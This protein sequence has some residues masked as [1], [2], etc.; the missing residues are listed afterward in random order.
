M[1]SYRKIG[2]AF[3]TSKCCTYVELE[4][5][6]IE[7]KAILN[8]RTITPMFSNPNDLTA[9]TSGHF[10]I[11]KP[12]LSR[13]GLVSHLKQEFWN[14]WSTEYLNQLHRRHYNIN[15]GDLVIIIDENTSGLQWPLWRKRVHVPDVKTLPGIHKRSVPS[16]APLRSRLIRTRRHH[17]LYTLILQR[18]RQITAIH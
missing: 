18:I 11:G 6:I 12:L 2:K 1:G 15:K 3:A 14:R 13:W 10:L 7:F 4:T 8:S 9:L 16:L 17:S 5:V